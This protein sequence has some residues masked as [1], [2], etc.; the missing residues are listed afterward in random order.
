MRWVDNDLTVNEEFIGLYEVKS[1]EAPSLVHVI[2][3]TLLRLNLPLSKVRGQCYDGASNM[4]GIRNGVA[5]LIQDEEPRSTFTHCYGHSLNLAAKDTIQNC[6]V[7]KSSLDTTFEITKLVKYSPRRENLFNDIKEEIEPGSVGVRSLCPTRW[8]VRADAMQTI[9]KNYKVLQELWEQA[10][11]VARDT[12][13]IARIQ[14]VA[15]QMKTF[16]YFFGLVFG[17]MLL[18]HADN[19]SRTLQKPC[20][21]SEGQ[22]IADMTE[23][24]CKR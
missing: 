8:T 10:A 18:R 5:K 13:T 24:P 12:E 15:S 6:K 21:A 11:G 20:S 2:K 4:R 9:I 23:E 14:G 3:D 7:L 1:I 22:S 19:L 16:E 17:E